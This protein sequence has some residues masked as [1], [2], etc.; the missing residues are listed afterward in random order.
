MGAPLLLLLLYFIATSV[1]G[2]F[3]LLPGEISFIA[4][5]AVSFFAFAG[6]LSFF[7]LKKYKV[8]K[9]PK[10]GVRFIMLYLLLMTISFLN[11]AYM[12]LRDGDSFFS[13]AQF[14][15][16]ILM[17][18][19]IFFGYSHIRTNQESIELFF[20]FVIAF[21]VLSSIYN[22]IINQSSIINLSLISSTYETDF[23]AFFFNRN[24][25]GFMMAL[26]LAVTTYMWGNHKKI[27]YVLAGVVLA[28]SLFLTMSRGALL[29]LFIFLFIYILLKSRSRI[30]ALMVILIV[31]AVSL[32]AIASN[33]FLQDNIIRAESG[34]TGRGELQEHGLNYYLN[35]NLLL[36]SGQ[37]AVNALENDMG[38]TS[39][40]N[41]YIETLV[42]QGMLGIVIIILGIL[43]SYSTIRKLKYINRSMYIFFFACLLAYVPYVFFEALP[44]FYATPNSVLITCVLI[45]FPLVLSNSIARNRV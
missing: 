29:F 6:L 21:L 30:R 14:F 10:V 2:L 27:R 16:P 45:I 7:F 11:T 12:A 4:F 39:Y 18:I 32:P 36:G 24:V 33:S 1:P 26:G 3:G 42:T 17:L 25:F 5:Q 22:L 9:A 34:D 19:V 37:G 8:T 41:L 20:K 28:S 13:M 38:H 43:F 15:L 40:H 35:N 23:R 31:I 44:L